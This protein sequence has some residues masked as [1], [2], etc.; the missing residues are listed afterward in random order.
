MVCCAAAGG[1]CIA[2]P[3]GTS[4]ARAKP[5]S[6]IANPQ[7]IQWRTR[8]VHLVYWVHQ[9]HQQ[10]PHP[11]RPRTTAAIKKARFAHR[12]IYRPSQ[13]QTISKK[14]GGKRSEFAAFTPGK[15]DVSEDGLTFHAFNSVT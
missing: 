4:I 10:A 7:G 13:T 2:L 8:L 12:H 3:T 15:G 5:H 1:A 9:V 11:R 6:G 14:R